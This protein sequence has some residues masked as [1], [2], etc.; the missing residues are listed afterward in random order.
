MP[1]AQVVVANDLKGIKRTLQ[2]TEA[3]VFNAPALVPSTGYVVTVEKAGFTKVELK[4]L[5]VQ[6]GQNLDLPVLL[7][8]AGTS[9]Q[10]EVEATAPVVDA[11]KTDVS[12]VIGSRQIADLPI[13]GRRVDSFVLLSPAVVPDGNFGLLSFRGVAGHNA[14]LTDGNDTTN[15][16]FNENAGRTRIQSP[17]SQEAV[18]EFQVVSNNFSAEYGNAMGGVVNTVTKSGTNDIHGTGYWFFRNRSL[19]A[20]D[21]YATFNPKDTRHQVGASLGGAFLKDKVFYF[22]NYEATR[23]DFPAIA[24]VTSANLFTAAGTLDTARNPCNASASQCDAVIKM[25][26]TRNFGTVSRKITQDL[27]FG[28]IDYHLN[29]KNSLSFSLSMLRW[30]SPH[31]IQ[32]T[33]IVFNTGNAI[34]NNGDSTVRN[35]FGRAQWTKVIGSTVV[36]E[37]RFGWFKDRLYDPASDDFLY[38]GLGRAQLSVNSTGNLGVATNYPRLNPSETRFSFADNISVIKGKH[39]MK[40]GVEIGHTED[41]YTQLANQYGTY[42]YNTLTAFALD[43]SGNTTGAKNWNTYSQRFGNP[44]VDTNLWTYGFYGQDTYRVNSALILNYG[45]RYDY[46][47]IPQP[48]IVNPDYPASGVIPSAKDNI[49]PRVGLSY[50][51]G[52][53]RKTLFRAGYGI[54]YAR[55]QSGLIN[56]FFLNNN[57]YQQS[58]TYNSATPAQLAAGP[59]YP[60]NLPSTSF[61]PP[62]GTVDIT[63]ADKNLRNPYTQQANVG[64]EREITSTMSLNVSY[65]WSRGVRLYGVRDLNVGPLGAPVTYKIVDQTGTQTGTYT[66]ATYRTPRPDTRYRRVNQVE[67]P[68][69]SYYDGLAVQL[70]K[71]LSHNFQAGLAYTWAHAIDLNQSNADNNIFF[72][73]GPTSFIN[74]DFASEKGSAAS[75]VRHRLVI[76]SVW[77]PV[78]TKSNGVLARYL[79]NNWQLSQVTTLQSARPVNSTTTVSGNAF[80]GA[81]VSGSLNGCGCGFSRVPF[82][83]VSN[84]NLDQIYRVDARLAKRLPFSERVNL[85]LQFEAFNVFNTPYDTGRRTDKYSLNIATSTLSYIAS[86]G[87]GNSTAASPDG[88]TARRA[89]VS[90][91]LTF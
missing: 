8:V 6:V 1:G 27:G 49:A 87:T 64:I 45:V 44:M 70:N 36:N 11:T 48:T 7:S 13:N 38:P 15:T 86:Y 78:F 88:T 73:S 61:T 84:L 32:S 35:A 89:Q 29:D 56:T 58:I 76:N 51:I 30:V 59:V 68:G 77:M 18:Q 53:S 33:G 91:R 66:T 63:V 26:T 85:Y 60:N 46:T 3:G 25:L 47:K 37:A 90:L 23:R 34:G 74:G 31:G 69:L 62:A 28:K 42:S 52:A 16:F 40:F 71:R 50:A 83:P 17:I 75:D 81:L 39:S 55:V 79:I 72:S 82:E 41:F 14:F 12:Q 67:N 19:N 43:F 4:D 80:T 20:R 5:Q 22:F 24:S 54:F 21:R 2:T 65:L 9:T 57:V 10:V